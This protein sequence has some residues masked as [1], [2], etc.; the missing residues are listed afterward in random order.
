[1]HLH[2]G[3]ACSSC[4]AAHSQQQQQQSQQEQQQAVD[5]DVLEQQALGK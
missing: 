4:P 2:G 5:E 3:H 1:M